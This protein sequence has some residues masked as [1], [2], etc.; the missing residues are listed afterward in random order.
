MGKMNLANFRKGFV[1]GAHCCKILWRP[2][3]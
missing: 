1:S 2:G 3:S